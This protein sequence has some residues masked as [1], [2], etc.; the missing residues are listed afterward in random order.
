MTSPYTSSLL[1]DPTRP[2]APG[3]R[4]LHTRDHVSAYAQAPI[5][6]PSHQV[7]HVHHHPA[8]SMQPQV[9]QQPQVMYVGQQSAG[10]SKLT[11]VLMAVIVLV[12]GFVAALAGYYAAQQA[13]PSQGEAATVQQVAATEG[14][15]TGRQRGEQLGRSA[16]FERADQL[17]TLRTGVAN[18]RAWNQGYKRGHKLGMSS[19]RKEPT[20]TGG[21]GGSGYSG[22]RGRSYGGSGYGAIQG[23][24]FQAQGLADATGSPV[25]VQVY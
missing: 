18:Q 14:F 19:Y 3:S 5:A 15:F 24:L 4:H 7:T 8:P 20:Y 2:S 25:D 17:A 16:G 1:Q 12:L 22:Y 9:A 13:A 11:S 10:G 23:A 21:Y 6:P